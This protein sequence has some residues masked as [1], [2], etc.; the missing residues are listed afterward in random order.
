MEQVADNIIS[1]FKEHPRRIIVI[2][3]N[4]IYADIWDGISFFKK[5]KAEKELCIYDSNI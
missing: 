3:F 4:P 5:K 2:Y 1:T